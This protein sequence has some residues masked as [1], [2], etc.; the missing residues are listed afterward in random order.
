MGLSI[1][2]AC[3]SIIFLFIIDELS[4]DRYHENSDDIYRIGIEA[5]LQGSEMK[6]FVLGSS[7]GRTF[8]NEIPEFIN[9]ARVFRFEDPIIKYDD[10][11]F[12][13]DNVFYAD[14]DSCFIILKHTGQIQP[15]GTAFLICFPSIVFETRVIILFIDSQ[16][17]SIDLL[18]LGIICPPFWILNDSILRVLFRKL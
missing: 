17:Q 8:V 1:G 15:T 2:M 14:T 11:K 3:S 9:S 4:Y 16:Q 10:K 18:Q 13:E 6:A 5:I 12:S 7:V